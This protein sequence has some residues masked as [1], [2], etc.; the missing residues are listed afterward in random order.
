MCML[1]YGVDDVCLML[2]ANKCDM[3]ESRKVSP[4]EG[5]KVSDHKSIILH[6]R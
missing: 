2:I 5:Q 3:T 6:L 4:E 1:Q